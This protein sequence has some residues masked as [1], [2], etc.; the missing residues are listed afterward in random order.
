MVLKITNLIWKQ[1]TIG[2]ELVIY[3][4]ETLKPTYNNTEYILFRKM[5]HEWVPVKYAFPHF[6]Y[7]EVV[8]T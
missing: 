7:V 5:V 6:Y 2:H 8:V 1:E 3:W 4:K